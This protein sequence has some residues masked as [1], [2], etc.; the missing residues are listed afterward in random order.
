MSTPDTI[1]ATPLLWKGKPLPEHLSTVRATWMD[2]SQR[3]WK[4][5]TTTLVVRTLSLAGDDLTLSDGATSAT[6]NAGK[7]TDK[8]HTVLPADPVRALAQAV[9]EQR[10]AQEALDAVAVPPPGAPPAN[11]LEL[12]S[13]QR[14][15]AWV[16]DEITEGEARVKELKAEL[17]RLNQAIVDECIELGIDKPLALDGLTYWF[18]PVYQVVYGTN[19][20]GDKYQA[21]DVIAALRECGLDIGL[22]KPTYHGGQLRSMLTE[23]HDEGLELPE[24]LARVLKLESRSAVATTSAAS[25]SLK[26][27]QAAKHSAT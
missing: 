7:L 1:A 14:R 6:L 4:T 25:K 5:R 22:V 23:R 17:D 27:R 2:T 19:E 3:S 8:W 24:P 12:A 13:M 16:R 20:D 26:G 11:P 18:R 10:A 9:Q 15:W 21:E